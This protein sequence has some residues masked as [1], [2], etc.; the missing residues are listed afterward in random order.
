MAGTVS[1]LIYLIFLIVFRENEQIDFNTQIRPI[2]NNKCIT[3]HGGVKQ[4]GGF[5]LLFPEEALRPN[6]SGKPA[7]VP[8]H[9]GKSEMIKRI[10]HE[11]PEL[12]MPL[13]KDPLSEEE[14]R[15][16]T[17]WIEQGAEWE[18]HWAFVKPET[19]EVL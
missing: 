10:T 16:I 2:L 19:V 7:I 8:G 11:D 9:P 18:D 12:R 15:L 6:E 3:C 13:E 14:I 17:A 4:S 5:S 1:I